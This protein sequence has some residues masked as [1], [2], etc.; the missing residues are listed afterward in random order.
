MPITDEQQLAYQYMGEKPAVISAAAGSGKTFVLAERVQ[1]LLSRPE[2]GIRADRLAVVTFTNKAAEELKSRL[3]V[4]LEY[5]A[6]QS[7]SAYLAEQ[8]GRFADARISTISSFC[9]QLLRENIT[10]TSWD[11]GFDMLDEADAAL[12]RKKA[13]KSL[14]TEIYADREQKARFLSGFRNENELE[15]TITDF[16]EFAASLGDIDQ[17]AEKQRENFTEDGYR[18][19]YVRPLLSRAAEVFD[20]CAEE[21]SNLTQLV[22]YS[23]YGDKLGVYLADYADALKEMG[24]AAQSDPKRIPD[25][26][27]KIPARIPTSKDQDDKACAEVIKARRDRIKKEWEKAFG[28]IEAAAVIEGEPEECGELFELIFGLYKRYK[29][30]YTELK[31]ENNCADFSDVEQG[32][33][34]LLKKSPQTAEKIR[35]Q[36]DY[37]IVDEFQDSNDIQYEIF[38]LLSRKGKNLY[39]VGDVKQ[40]IYGFRNAN[41]YILAGLLD[42]PRWQPLLMNMNFRSSDNVIKSVN[43]AFGGLQSQSFNGGLPWENMT[44]GRGIEE[45]DANETELVL[46]DADKSVDGKSPVEKEAEYVAARISRMVRDGFLIHDKGEVRPARYGDFA[47]LLRSDSAKGPVYRKALTELGIPCVNKGERNYTDLSEV[48]M[49]VN[50]LKTL[51]NPF[52]DNALAAVLMSPL[53]RFDGKDMAELKLMGQGRLFAAV[54]RLAGSTDDD[55]PPVGSCD[56]EAQ[57]GE[58]PDDRELAAKAKAFISDYRLLRKISGDCT[59]EKLLR[60]LYTMTDLL[61]VMSVGYRGGERADNL[62]LLLHYGAK[63]ESV[64]DFILFM[65]NAKRNSLEMKT[66]VQNEEEERS[67]KI[68]TIHGSKGLQYPVVFLSDTNRRPNMRDVTAP[69]ICDGKAGIGLMLTDMS[70]PVRFVTAC[71]TAVAESLAD[72]QRGEELRLLY[73]AMTR[74]IDKLIITASD[75]VKGEPLS[76]SDAAESGSFFE[77]LLERTEENSRL[78]RFARIA[79]AETPAQSEKTGDQAAE[80][81]VDREKIKKNLAFSYPYKLQTKAPAK[82]T[83]T[84]LGVER[85]VMEDE[86]D[87]NAFYLSLPLFMKNGRKITGKEKGDIYHKVMEN[88]DFADSNARAQLDRMVE[89]GTL[90]ADERGAVKTEDIEKFLLSPLCRRITASAEVEREFPIFTLVNPADID[91]ADQSDLSFLQGIADLYF[92]EQGEI[93]LVDYKTNTNVTAD[94]LRHTYKGQLSIYKKALEE[95]TGLPVKE[96]VLYSFSLG[97]TIEVEV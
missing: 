75:K 31:L 63:Y 65:E 54:N 72:K 11:S 74:A 58:M 38:R 45:C 36:L 23:A 93:V 84:Q 83:A 85:S 92:E 55:L 82:V 16:Y 70:K 48:Q 26:K 49:V 17:W 96:C 52:D 27:K 59:T 19:T 76:P 12:L 40:C 20:R 1:Y 32:L 35:S 4:R 94:Y 57:D 34:E 97:E 5:E 47:V 95:M 13:F 79:A 44:A 33:L 50:L 78:C 90:T 87:E 22:P 42:N 67:V 21:M 46:V 60:R 66:A 81:T 53:Y 30:I 10:R 18:E 14:M 64:Q 3:T 86:T 77:F 15:A 61:S 2:A 71:H 62:R 6:E 80:I 68:I 25:L 41:P 29:S 28:Y 89:D 73:V 43:L 24:E 37:I 8:L 39:F 7:G 9:L 69:V 88:I 91:S 51:V 56:D